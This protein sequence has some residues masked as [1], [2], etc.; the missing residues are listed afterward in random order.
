MC[1]VHACCRTQ[2]TAALVSMHH[3]NC[4]THAG[5]EWWSFTTGAR[6]AAASLVSRLWCCSCQTC[7]LHN[8][9]VST[10][11]PFRSNIKQPAKPPLRNSTVRLLQSHPATSR[12]SLRRRLRPLQLRMQ[13][14]RRQR[15][16]PKLFVPSFVWLSFRLRA[17]QY[18]TEDIDASADAM[19]SEHQDVAQISVQIG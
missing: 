15:T 19:T 10:G 6:A 18:Y 7:G 2:P 13:T 9:R 12:A 17:L 5:T 8:L 16:N 3:F 1:R 11:R 14:A 4:I